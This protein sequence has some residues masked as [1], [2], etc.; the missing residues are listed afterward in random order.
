MATAADGHHG[1]RAAV[2][3]GLRSGLT[4]MFLKSVARSGVTRLGTLMGGGEV[5]N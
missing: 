1:R 4:H 3:L 5:E 2:E